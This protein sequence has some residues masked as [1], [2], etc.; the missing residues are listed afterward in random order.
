MPLASCPRCKKMFNKGASKV[1]QACSGDEESDI[2]KITRIMD[3]HIDLDA[4][5]I[6][7]KAEVDLAVVLRLIDDGR[8]A[9]VRLD[10]N[11]MCGRCGAP[12]IS[13]SKKLCQ[14]CLDDLNAEV[15]K[16]RS[17]IRLGEKKQVQ[18]G[19]Y[20]APRSKDENKR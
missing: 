20:S 7:E 15:M 10:A 4:D 16:A 13:M 3:A 17:G 1:C 5:E 12:A 9:A 11:V 19:M 2:E 14:K 8:L 18:L 6:A